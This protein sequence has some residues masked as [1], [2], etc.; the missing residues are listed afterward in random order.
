VSRRR[1]LGE[2]CHCRAAPQRAERIWPALAFSRPEFFGAGRSYD[3]RMT[4]SFR[5]D[6]NEIAAALVAA[7]GLTYKQD[8]PEGLK[9]PLL[10]W[11][12]YRSRY[13]EPRPRAVLKATGFDSRVPQPAQP[14]LRAFIAAAESGRDLNAF[15]TQTT[16]RNDTS[17]RKRQWRTDLLWADWGILHAHLIDAPAAAAFELSA[18]SDWLVFFVDLGERLLLIDV[19]AHRE[20]GVFQAEDI[21]VRMLRSWPELDKEPE[22]RGGVGLSRAAAERPADVKARREGGLSGFL[23]IDGKVYASPGMGVTTASTST[24]VSLIRNRV[25]SLAR[26]LAA[27][28]QAPEGPLMVAARDCGAGSVTPCLAVNP[29]G[30]LVAAIG[31]VGMRL[32]Q[33]GS[34]GLELQEQFLPSWAG[35]RLVD[36]HNKQRIV[37][38]AAPT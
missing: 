15:Q 35:K 16:K 3:A 33:A 12:D 6:L 24:R 23:V 29:D 7:F 1:A 32:K 27:E 2:P 38:T 30:D 11:L 21:A 4:R 5:D 34:A 14:G 36:W 8:G 31:D 13:I 28:V 17:G 22:P 19:R 37:P 25:L 26:H 10:R 9:D 18:T 20:P